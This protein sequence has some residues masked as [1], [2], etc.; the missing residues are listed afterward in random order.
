MWVKRLGSNGM[1]T[2]W[3][4]A[5]LWT[6]P[7]WQNRHALAIRVLDFSICGQQNLASRR[8]HTRV[9]NG[10]Q[11]LENHLTHLC[12]HQR[13]ENP[14]LGIGIKTDATSIG[15]PASGL[16]VRYGSIPVLD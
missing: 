7:N 2:G 14:E 5:C 16:S 12:G 8:P 3:S 1:A 6:L 13:A 11:Q 15:I 9:A 10:V 4:W